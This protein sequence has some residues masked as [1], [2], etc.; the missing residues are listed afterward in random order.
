MPLKIV[1]SFWSKPAFDDHQDYYNSRQTAGW[2]NLRYFLLSSCLSCLT[3]IRHHKRIELHTD[4]KGYDYLIDLLQLPYNDVYLSLNDLN[5]L[6]HRLWVQAKFKAF[7]LQKEPF[8][9]IDNDVYLWKEL[10]Q[11]VLTH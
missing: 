6:D 9:H 4:Q 1:H 11:T 7:K 3:A 2:L 8:I 10:F 5:H